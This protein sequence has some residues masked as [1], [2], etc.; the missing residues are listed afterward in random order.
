[1][2]QVPPVNPNKIEESARS[3][4]LEQDTAMTNLMA[5]YELKDTDT[6]QTSLQTLAKAL[7]VPTTRTV[8]D[9]K[10]GVEKTE[11]IKLS[12]KSL[13]IVAEQRF[14]QS[15]QKM[16]LFSNLMDRLAQ[17]KQQLIN[18]MKN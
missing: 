5:A 6:D 4:G 10:S 8:V 15:S 3:L 2:T 17:M 12:A 14:Q 16:T 9:P 18:N 7:N 13:Q 11:T 1:M